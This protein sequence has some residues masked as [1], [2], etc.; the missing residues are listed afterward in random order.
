ML[1]E[2]IPA[3]LEGIDGEDP[4]EDELNEE[5][6]TA[7]AAL[8]NIDVNDEDVVLD[9]AE[10]V[11]EEKNIENAV[12]KTEIDKNCNNKRA[13]SSGDCAVIERDSKDAAVDKH[14]RLE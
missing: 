14:V 8:D 6:D 9:A 10:K 12:D 11:L 1:G 5:D 2:E 13:L 3:E 4:S 7:E